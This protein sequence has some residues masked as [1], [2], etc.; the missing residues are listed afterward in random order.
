MPSIKATKLHT[1]CNTVSFGDFLLI[2]IYI[3]FSHIKIIKNQ[4]KCN[5]IA[6]EKIHEKRKLFLKTILSNRFV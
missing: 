3:R 1:H 5:C 6:R 4:Y 2:Q